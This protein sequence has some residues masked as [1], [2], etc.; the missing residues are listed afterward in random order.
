MDALEA[1]ILEGSRSDHEIPCVLV[2]LYYNNTR[3]INRGGPTEMTSQKQSQEWSGGGDFRWEVPATFNFSADVVDRWA[4]GS[5]TPGVDRGRRRRARAAL[6]LRRDREP[7][8]PALQS[9]RRTRPRTGRPH[10]R[11]AA[12]HPRVADRH[13]RRDAHGR[14]PD[15]VHHDADRVGPRVPRR[16]R[17][18]EGRDHHRSRR[19]R[20]SRGSAHSRHASASGTHPRDG[21]RS[22][23]RSSRS[24]STFEPAR[25]PAED[26]AILYYTSG[27][28]GPP[29]GVT[30][31]VARALGVVELG[32]ALARSRSRRSHLVHRRHG[33][34]EGGHEHPVR[35]VEPRFVGALLRRPLRAPQTLRDA[36]ALRGD[37]SSARPRPSC[38][39]SSSRTCRASISVGSARPSR[40]ASP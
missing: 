34:V 22:P 8:R 3:E 24:A 11:D 36:R 15:P 9:A 4:R 7:G 39:V 18:C 35:A 13:G 1:Q 37:L 32:G 5:G 19:R 33:L 25:V 26:P 31:A 16:A 20:S 28:T 14:S 10:R 30:H 2:L 40:P 29:K 6:H 38:G 23:T 27:S 12:A 21:S 17:G